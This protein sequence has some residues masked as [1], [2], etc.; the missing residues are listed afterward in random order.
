MGFVAGELAEFMNP[1]SEGS[2]NQVGAVVSLES[3]PPGFEPGCGGRSISRC[4][5][6]RR[7]RS[8]SPS[9]FAGH[10]GRYGSRASAISWLRRSG[11]GPEEGSDSGEK[12][13]ADDPH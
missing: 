8:R 5:V 2:C 9:W 12:G 7:R 3:D 4:R 11:S 13:T 10:T 1:K 6:T